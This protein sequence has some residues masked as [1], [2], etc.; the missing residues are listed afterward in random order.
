MKKLYT[1]AILT[2]L[3]NVT[4]FGQFQM[5][6]KQGKT[7]GSRLKTTQKSHL[8]HSTASTNA[9][10]WSDDFSSSA[11]W[12]LTHEPGTDGDWVI[13][14]TGPAGAAAIN[15][16][17]S[18]TAGNGFAKFDSDSICS[19]NQIGNLTNANPIDLSGSPS[20]KLEFSQYYARYYD[21]T[22]IYVS[23]D[24]TNWTRFE[25][26]GNLLINEYNGNNPA[27]NP[28]IVSI[29]ISSV[30][31]NQSTV[32]I[33]FQFYSPST[34]NILA[35]CGY[36]W[37]IDDVSISEISAID[38]AAQPLAF[39]GEYSIISL[40][41]T[42]AFNLSGR[43]INK[44]SSAI[45]SGTLTFN[46]YNSSGQVYT[47]AATIS[48]TINP[49]DTSA[50]LTSAG[51]Y[52]P[53]DTG[54]YVIEQIV[55]IPGDSFTSNDTAEAFVIVNDSIN[56]R[57]YTAINGSSYIA[58]GS[59]FNGNKGVLGQVYHIYQS[60]QV[61]SGTFYLESPIVGDS[62]SLSL[63]SMTSGLPDSASVQSSV[64]YEITANDTIGG[65]GLM[66]TL[67]F[68]PPIN[69]TSGDYFLGVNQVD[70]NYLSL[71]V[72]NNIFTPGKG[73]FNGSSGWID[74]GNILQAV[75][76][77]RLNNPSSTLVSVSQTDKGKYFSVYPN[78]TNGNIKIINSGKDGTVYVN[79]VNALGSV[80]KSLSF[81]SF[82]EETIDLSNLKSGN[83]TIQFIA[84]DDV[85]NE[86][87]V[88]INGK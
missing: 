2:F 45:S 73:F 30:A 44:G 62:V 88:L 37:M 78:P 72:A 53:T 29:D 28:D 50:I 8:T 11:N 27:L 60:S 16:I 42:T 69:V 49:G 36:S 82:S 61:T 25:V 59:G 86:R 75:F 4:A 43:V 26:N 15:I 3:I 65:N 1:I 20:V 5:R 17:Q 6:N 74:V 48:S 76:I 40:L 13:G 14:L 57:D 51:A 85:V 31:G 19:G 12:V 70:T 52:A 38:A 63:F 18:A 34:I 39:G 80:V 22:Y 9:I 77:L 10:L 66:L 47:D 32:W 58:G 54:F 23:S 41:N 35:G 67:P 56:A 33:R 21:S 83:Y 46:V 81:K 71:G 84:G 55:S 64:A 68:V 7:L 87:V 24:S 79:V